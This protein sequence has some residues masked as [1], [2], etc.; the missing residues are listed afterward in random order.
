VLEDHGLKQLDCER[1]MWMPFRVLL[2]VLTAGVCTP[3]QHPPPGKR[4]TEGTV[5]WL[6]SSCP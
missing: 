5:S 1:A 6:C 4:N 3:H 2:V